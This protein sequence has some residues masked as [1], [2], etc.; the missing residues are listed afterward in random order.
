MFRKFVVLMALFCSFN[1][2][3][4]AQE[5]AP[6]EP[7]KETA[8]A[9]VPVTAP[10][11]ATE[12]VWK[13]FFPDGISDSEGKSVDLSVLDGKIVGLYFS[14]HWCPP[15][16]AFSPKL[17]EFRNANS[18]DFEVVFISSDK[19]ESAQFEYMKEVKMEWPT[20]KHRSDAANALADKYGVQ[21]IPTL[22]ILSPKGETLSTDGRSD[23]MSS[24]EKCIETWKSQIK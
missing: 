13:T 11:P 24:P 14:A 1:G 10:A 21:G 6:A 18:A 16:R 3:L 19:S 9:A 4:F 20:M 7:Q 12:S 5:P 8:P 23:V 22:I 17:V 15:C 2:G